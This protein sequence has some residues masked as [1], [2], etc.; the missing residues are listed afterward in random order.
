MTPQQVSRGVPAPGSS[1]LSP[2][3][4][5]ASGLR[6]SQ[7]SFLEALGKAKRQDTP[8]SAAR[9][10]AEQWVAATLV[11]PLLKQLR[12]MNTAAPPFSPGPGEK[13]FGAL[14][15][16]QVA[17]QIVTAKHF[18]LVDRV[19]RQLLA[20]GGRPPE[21]PAPPPQAALARPTLGALLSAD[22]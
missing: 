9:D 15:D 17:H 11:Q 18:P 10:A 14:M 19:A 21:V 1:V 3:H 13:Q 8:E 5:L 22:R 4:G 7:Q 6:N 20:K 2:R 12:D 16:A